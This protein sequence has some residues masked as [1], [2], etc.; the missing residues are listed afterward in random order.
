MS[1][2]VYVTT[3]RR[4]EPDATPLRGRGAGLP[5]FHDPG[6]AANDGMDLRR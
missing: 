1:L 4:I 5:P 2:R 3:R 6:A